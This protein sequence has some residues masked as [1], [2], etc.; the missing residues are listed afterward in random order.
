M[1]KLSSVAE[2]IEN[3]RYAE[4][5]M[6]LNGGMRSTFP[7]H[8]GFV[9]KAP[10]TFSRGGSF[11]PPPYGNRVAPRTVATGISMA[12]SATSYSSPTT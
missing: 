8:P 7:Q 2:A 6:S 4:E 11:R 1:W 5:H 3:A 10:R 12:A 9:E